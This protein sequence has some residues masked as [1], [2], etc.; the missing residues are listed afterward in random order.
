MTKDYQDARKVM[1]ELLRKRPFSEAKVDLLIQGHTALTFLLEK[2]NE[3]VEFYQGIIDETEE[4]LSRM[5]IQV[6]ENKKVV[7]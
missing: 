4:Y 7:V 2:D 1:K 6:G 3:H 5:G